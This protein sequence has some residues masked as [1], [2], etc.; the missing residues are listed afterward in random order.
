MKAMGWFDTNVNAVTSS[1]Q[2]IAALVACDVPN[3]MVMPCNT[4]GNTSLPEQ[5]RYTT[6]V[7]QR[8]A[9]PVTLWQ[10]K[11]AF[12]TNTWIL[13]RLFVMP[14]MLSDMRDCRCN[15]LHVAA[16]QPMLGLPMLGCLFNDANVVAC[17]DYRCKC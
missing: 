4:C 6:G 3:H 10:P 12:A 1:T 11:K 9:R 14:N 2:N 17:R 5:V 16:L 7:M 8:H 13:L 15:C